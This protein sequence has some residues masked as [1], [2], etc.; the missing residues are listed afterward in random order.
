MLDLF[1]QLAYKC[2]V[3]CT[4]LVG[5]DFRHNL[6]GSISELQRRYRL[7]RVVNEGTHGGDERRASVSTQ[8]ILQEPGDF[9]ITVANVGLA[10]A[11]G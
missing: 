9:R 11:L 3:L 2:I 4:H 1:L 6:L 10:L 5:A 7:L 8:T